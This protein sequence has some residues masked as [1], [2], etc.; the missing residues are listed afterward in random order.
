M[1]SSWCSRMSL[2]LWV[3]LIAQPHPVK[4][5]FRSPL[6]RE[7]YT[8]DEVDEVAKLIVA[9]VLISRMMRFY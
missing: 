9:L 3:L 4:V 7:S 8:V 1:Y 6:S 2:R 5:V